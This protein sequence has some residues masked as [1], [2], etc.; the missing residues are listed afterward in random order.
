MT[1]DQQSLINKALG[2]STL[3]YAINNKYSK[4]GIYF[5]GNISQQNNA[6]LIR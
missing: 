6:W 1:Y 3:K 5:S 2:Y 4:S